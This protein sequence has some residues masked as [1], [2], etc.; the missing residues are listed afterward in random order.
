MASTMTILLDIARRQA[1]GDLGAL[2]AG[3]D[4]E[5]LA[6]RLRARFPDPRLE[7][8]LPT[9]LLLAAPVDV[10]LRALGPVLENALAVA[11]PTAPS[12]VL[13]AEPGPGTQVVL[14]VAD[15][16]PGIAADVADRVF[17]PGVTGRGGSGLGLPL[18]RRV[19]RSV[20]GDV[21]LA[22]GAGAGPGTV[23]EVVLPG[24]GTPLRT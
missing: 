16:G 2:D 22:A 4:A 11:G 10:V 8:R 3:T 6:T 21:R 13:D 15:D 19:A 17:E 14:R 1:A 9:D 23:F 5:L 18:A 20:G 24:A 12:V 7:L